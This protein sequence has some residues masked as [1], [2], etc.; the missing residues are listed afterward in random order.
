MCQ[1]TLNSGTPKTKHSHPIVPWTGTFLLLSVGRNILQI[2]PLKKDSKNNRKHTESMLLL[3][4]HP[5]LILRST[6]AILIKK[7]KKK[8]NISLSLAFSQK[9]LFLRV[10]IS[11][12]LPPKRLLIISQNTCLLQNS[13]M[14]SR[15]P[16]SDIDYGF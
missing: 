16:S 9:I 1:S 3:S 6:S 14:H 7:K 2:V 5:F 8:T 15:N 10:C 4:F 11:L 13:E 12:Y